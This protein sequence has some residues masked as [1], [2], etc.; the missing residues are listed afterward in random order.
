MKIN[1]NADLGESFGAWTMGDD[2][3]LLEVVGAANIACGFHA[4]DPLVMRT[5]LRLALARGVEIGAH[6]SYPDLQGFG[7]RPM[8]M[9]PA[10]LE[11]A[12]IY[13][14]G[15]LAGM[16]TAEGGR[17]V[18]VKPHGALSNQACVDATLADTVARAM[19]AFDRGLILLAPARSELAAAGVRAALAVAQE[20]FA[21]RA[22]AEDGS[23]LPRSEPGAVLAEPAACVAQ[24]LAMLEAG[25]IVTTSGAKLP[26][27]IHSICVHGDS[28]HAV[29]TARALR[30]AL[31]TAGHKLV[32]LAEALSG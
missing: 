5:T 16:V 22:Y 20:V 21:D 17:L 7:R 27:L 10:E 8:K 1:L 29:A 25:G 32:G 23:L 12:L 13:Q 9:D 18:H 3:A 24:V 6:P 30:A 26:T 2:A 28:P 31:H 19:T 15:A 11:A 4:G 14:L